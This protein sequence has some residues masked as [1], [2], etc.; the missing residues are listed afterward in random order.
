V[1]FS[2]PN[3]W[4]KD[5]DYDG[6]LYFAQRLEEMLFHYSI[7]IYKAPILNTNQLIIEYLETGN[8]VEQGKV[9]ESNLDYIL[10]EFKDTFQNDIVLKKY[11]GQ[12]NIERVLSAINTSTKVD[13]LKLMDY[14]QHIFGGGKY[15]QWCVE[16]LKF[17]I[18]QQKEKKKI[19]KAIKCFLPEL[20]CRGYTSEY[21]YTYTQRFF[22]KN[23][24][25]SMSSLNVFLE[26]FSFTNKDFKVYFGVSDIIVNFKDILTKMLKI[27]FEDDGNFN[28][29]KLPK[30]FLTVYIKIKALDYYSA[31]RKAYEKF[32][33]F[34][35]FYKFISHK[36]RSLIYKIGMT[37]EIN[38][39]AFNVLA[40]VPLGY[41]SIEEL[42]IPTAGDFA[43]TLVTTL[44]V[45]AKKEFKILQKAIDLHNTALSN[46][47]YETGFLNL[48]SVIE[49]LCIP[50]QNDSKIKEVIKILVPILQKD[51]LVSLFSDLRAKIS[52]VLEKEDYLTLLKSVSQDLDEQEKIACFV[53]LQEYEP[54]RSTYY[55]KLTNYP[56]LRSRIHEI[57]NSG[58]SKK[59]IFQITEKYKERVT[60]HIR[61]I[62]RVRN[63]IVHSGDTPNNIKAIGEHLH[64]YVDSLMYE[65]II[66]LSTQKE[67]ASIDNVLIDT[68]FEIQQF[69]EVFRR[70]GNFDKSTIK[71]ML[72][73]S[74]ITVQD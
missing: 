19:E 64:S 44:L 58:K 68:N 28:R 41:N 29:L 2:A 17:I 50:M 39:G 57:S 34:L 6:L 63:G 59:T 1:K 18:P 32:N 61:R 31:I 8:K 65:I 56:V 11:W 60:W 21:V 27:N 48:W 7:D 66:K 47:E 42:D 40:A 67:L 36:N 53:L 3:K 10:E 25:D 4:S 74:F 12:Q 13:Q 16:Y 54:L 35:K 30:D 14:L 69:Y 22:F 51:Y 20:I 62:Y 46:R 9:K 55:S 5:F 26:H 70:D 38:E 33:L 15:Y 37:F 73:P 23:K 71:Q 49:V 43:E 72:N 24:V 45:N 52:Q